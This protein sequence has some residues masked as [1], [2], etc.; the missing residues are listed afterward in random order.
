MDTD[1]SSIRWQNL[2]TLIYIYLYQRICLFVKQII[3]NTW[4]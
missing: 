2:H 1:S 4:L 3:S